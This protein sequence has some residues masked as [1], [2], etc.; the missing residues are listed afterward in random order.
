MDLN[1]HDVLHPSVLQLG[2]SPQ[3]PTSED[4]QGQSGARKRKRS[5]DEEDL[6]KTLTPSTTTGLSDLS[7]WNR[8]PIGAF[9]S[10]TM[11]TF[12]PTSQYFSATSEEASVAYS[13]RRKAGVAGS[14]SLYLPL[15]A[16]KGLKGSTSSLSHT[17]SSPHTSNSAATRRAIE[18]RMLQSP[19]FGPVQTSP[20]L[21]EDA[22]PKSRKVQ[23]K[24]KRLSGVY[25]SAHQEIA[26]TSTSPDKTAETFVNTAV[27]PPPPSFQ[28]SSSPFLSAAQHS[29]TPS[30]HSPLFRSSPITS[31]SLE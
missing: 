2:T 19:L 13:S 23:R 27:P 6:D 25:V 4:S 29:Y 9:R 16:H 11:P 7:R 15:A 10:S 5:I 30:L 28:S 24:E 17:L 1:L 18:R 22:S 3:S 12:S 8:I 20:S 26:A 31:T 14:N 21:L